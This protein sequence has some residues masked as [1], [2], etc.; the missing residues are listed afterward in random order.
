MHPVPTGRRCRSCVLV[1][2]VNPSGS[3]L[4]GRCREADPLL[5]EPGRTTRIRFAEHENALAQR[6]HPIRPSGPQGGAD[7]PIV[8][9][10]VNAS[11]PRSN[12][13][14]GR[15]PAT[16]GRPRLLPTRL[17]TRGC[18]AHQCARDARTRCGK[19]TGRTGVHQQRARDAVG[20]HRSRILPILE[21]R[22]RVP[23][24]ARIT[25]DQT[26]DCGRVR[27]R[28]LEWLESQCWRF[29]GEHRR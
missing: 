17:A 10:I 24:H 1:R 6:I 12:L 2:H 5:T 18:A 23:A 7:P 25:R 3:G 21:W 22:L 29:E 13:D 26:G 11:P 16:L 8:T 9:A 14:V 20:C 28:D 27:D 4:T 15:L 19:S